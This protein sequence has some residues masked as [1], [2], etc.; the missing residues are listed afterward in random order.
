MVA[1]SNSRTGAK[2]HHC[3]VDGPKPVNHTNKKSKSVPVR[4]RHKFCTWRKYKATLGDSSWHTDCGET[5]YS[6]ATLK[7]LRN[8]YCQYCGRKINEV[9][10]K[11]DDPYSL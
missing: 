7:D 5:L 4:P 11:D 8:V 2:R 9:V 10:T 6:G 1:L 3:D